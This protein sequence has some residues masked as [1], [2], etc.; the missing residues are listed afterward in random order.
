MIVAESVRRA[1]FVLLAALCLFPV[2]TAPVALTA[3]IA[4]AL[5]LGNPFTVQVGK[6]SG[7]LLKT[8]VVGLGFGLP[9][10]AVVSVGAT[11][12]WVTGIGVLA[13]LVSGLVLARV[14][15]LDSQCGGLISVGTAICGG[16]AIAAVAPVIGARADAISMSMA[17]V[18]ILNA[19]ALY[20]FP[21]LGGV[22]DLSQSQF[23]VWAAIAIHD[24]SS[25]VGAAATY[26]DQALAEATVLKLARALWIVPLVVGFMLLARRD[27]GR[28]GRIPWPLFVALFVLAAGLRSVLPGLEGTF[29]MLAGAARRG[30]VL[31]LFLIGSGLS[32]EALRGLGWRPLLHATALWLIVSSVTLLLVVSGAD[33]IVE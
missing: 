28:A 13:I 17:C 20:L 15:A 31:V 7:L 27:Q 1:A 22:L 12:L 8:C 19:V 2:I 14:F 10:T 16:S 29:D 3:G 32:V 23:A 4:F 11:G 18:F 24:T 25:V 30:L 9:L 26:G 6:V 21:W 33:A 5:L